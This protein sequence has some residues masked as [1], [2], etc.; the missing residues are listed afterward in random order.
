MPLSIPKAPVACWWSY[1]K[2][3]GRGDSNGS[4][5]RYNKKMLPHL[6]LDPGRIVVV[7]VSGGPDSLALLHCLHETP[8]PLIVA[9]FNHR[10]RP[11]AEADVAFVQQVAAE[12]GLPFV[13]DSADVAT[14]AGAEGLSLEEAAR[15]LRYRFLFRAAREAGAQAVAVGHTADDQA[16]TVLMH[17]LRG[18]GLS[19]LKGMPSRILLPIFDAEIPLVR[20]LLGWTRAE[21]EAYCRKHALSPRIDATNTDTTYFRNRLRHELLPELEKYNPQIRPA[22]AKT[23]LALQG[24]SDLLHDLI[25]AAWQKVVNQTG[26]GFVE[27]ERRQLESL[28]PALRR[29]LFRKAAFLLKPGLRDVDFDALERAATL[30][31]ADLAGGLKTIVEGAKLYLTEAEST[32]PVN[33]PQ[34]SDPFLVTDGQNDLGSDWILTCELI[35]HY[36]SLITDNWSAFF[37]ADLTEGRLRIRPVHTGDRFEPLGMRSQTVKLSDL[38]VNLK[39]PQRLR[40]KWPVICTEAEIVWVVGLRMAEP[41]KVTENT[42]R[43]LKIEIKKL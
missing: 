7:G 17:F 32:L 39:I 10:L 34:V 4:P 38:F 18:T 1:I 25:E 28:S 15:E 33:F 29:N 22:L 21:T 13:T 16:E 35:T 40:K 31:P 14:Y 41:F 43:V 27:F 2:S 6:G 5:R 3:N 24:D 42:R 8:Y 23:A 30:K 37:D 19:G 12:W 20:P 9:S 26:S 36:S 11:E